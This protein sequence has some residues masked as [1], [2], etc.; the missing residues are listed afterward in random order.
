MS[1]LLGMLKPAVGGIMWRTA[2]VTNV[3]GWIRRI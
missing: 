1:R 2:K 3:A